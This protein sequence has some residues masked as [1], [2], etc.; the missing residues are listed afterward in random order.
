MATPMAAPTTGVA[1][2]DMKASAVNWLRKPSPGIRPSWLSISPMISEANRPW[3]IAL[4]A[5]SR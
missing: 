5:S 2:P 1:L 4:N 3:P